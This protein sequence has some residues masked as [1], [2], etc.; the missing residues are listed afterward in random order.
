M[1]SNPENCTFSVPSGKLLE[2]MVSHRR[3]DP[4]LEKVLTIMKM[5]PPE[6][7]HDVQKLTG[8]MTALS[9]FIS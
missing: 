2:Y 4:N 6:S 8:W 3:I 1:K 9:R 7:L 5:K